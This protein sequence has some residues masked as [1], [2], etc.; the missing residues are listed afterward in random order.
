M[1][2]ETDVRE[3]TLIGFARGEMS[4]SG[5]ILFATAGA[6]GDALVI[7]DQ[8]PVHPVSF[9]WPD[10][11]ADQGVMIGSDGQRHPII[12]AWTG[13]VHGET[14]ELVLGE[15]AR[16]LGR[17]G[18]EWKSVVVHVIGG[19]SPKSG[20]TVAIEVDVDRRRNLSAAHT[21]AHLSAF[22]LNRAAKDYWSKAAASLD[23]LGNPD[24]DKEGIVSAVLSE[25]ASVDTYRVGKTLRKK[26][27]EFDRFIADMPAVIPAINDILRGWLAAPG[28]VS[29]TP[30]PST[31]D[32]RR[33]WQCTLDGMDAQMYC[34]GTH[35]T[36][37]AELAEVTVSIE[38]IESGVVMHTSVIGR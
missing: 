21:A 14:G 7:C 35:V 19:S 25:Q 38:A 6:D 13:L 36:N 28:A 8:T 20:D 5:K 23:S 33:L 32:T 24:F 26:G 17:T 9:R 2:F 31:L 12:D 11:P 16:A 30:A 1:R 10:Q 27:F 15:D 18:D 29:L 22:A 4:G 37:L 3:S 34:A